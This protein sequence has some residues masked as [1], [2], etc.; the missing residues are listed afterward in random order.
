M[1][2]SSADLTDPDPSGERVGDPLEFCTFRSCGWDAMRWDAM[3]WKVRSWL[4]L[5]FMQGF[6]GFA[7]TRASIRG[8]AW[9]W[10]SCMLSSSD[11]STIAGAFAAVL[12]IVDG[13][14]QLSAGSSLSPS[15]H[16]P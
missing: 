5:W 14:W 7:W 11:S 16:R 12:H 6:P 4:R 2:T 8:E 15:Q 10:S 13:H 3:E 1:S 9:A